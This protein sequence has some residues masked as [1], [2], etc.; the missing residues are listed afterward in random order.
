MKNPSALHDDELKSCVR[1]YVFLVPGRLGI[2][3]V[4]YDSP[5]VFSVATRMPLGK[6][7][8][9]VGGSLKRAGSTV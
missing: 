6:L 5:G 9:L 8:T 1:V 3:K 7:V 4:A 2:Y